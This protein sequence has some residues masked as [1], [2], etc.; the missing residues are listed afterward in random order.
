MAVSRTML[1]MLFL[2]GVL[3]ILFCV[4]VLPQQPEDI[5]NDG[6]YAS[7][8]PDGF[9]S[10]PSGGADG[11][12]NALSQLDYFAE[13]CGATYELGDD[14]PLIK[15]WDGDLRIN[16]TG[17]PDVNDMYVI[18]RTIRA[19]NG[20]TGDVRLSLNDTDSNVVFYIGAASH[21]GNYLPYVSQNGGFN[22]WYRNDST[23]IDRAAVAIGSGEDKAERAFQITYA[24]A[25]VLG[26]PGESTLY[27]DSI[28]CTPSRRQAS[29]SDMDRAV[30]RMLYDGR[31]RAGMTV[32]QARAALAQ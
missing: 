16:V 18:N 8:G 5:A 23:V 10:T 2:T 15:K 30:F 14:V 1:A 9:P 21:F 7:P 31:V 17:Q 32:E 13:I 24:F 12:D 6:S 27:P 26:C 3:A 4:M 20:L 25:V 22:V 28:F 19:L 29:Y 11:G